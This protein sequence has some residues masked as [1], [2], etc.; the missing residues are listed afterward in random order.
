[1]IQENYFD[2]NA[3]ARGTNGHTVSIGFI[4]LGK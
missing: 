4:I 2:K 1:M 3:V